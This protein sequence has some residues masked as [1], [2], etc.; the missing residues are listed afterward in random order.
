M[1]AERG[2]E[3]YKYGMESY[4]SLELMSKRLRNLSSAACCWIW[5]M[6]GYGILDHE[7]KRISAHYTIALIDWAVAAREE[8]AS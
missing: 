2:Y 8:M 1:L 5:V 4:S 3:A 6:S 7:L